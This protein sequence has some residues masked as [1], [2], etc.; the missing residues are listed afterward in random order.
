MG[1]ALRVNHGRRLP[2]LGLQRSRLLDFPSALQYE[3]LVTNGLG[4]YASGT[5][6]GI[7]T[8]RYHGLLMAALRPPVGRTLLFARLHDA[9]EV[10]DDHYPLHAAEYHDGTI[11][12]VGYL[13]LD[14]VF[15]DGRRPVWRY[16]CH[17]VTLEKSLWLEH[18][19][20]TLFVRYRVVAAP[21]RVRLRLEPF[22]THRADHA[23]THGD[24]AWRFLVD[25]QPTHCR[26]EAFPGATPLWLGLAPGHFVETG[27]WYWRFLHRR[28]R[29]RGLDDLEDLYTPGVFVIEMEPGEVAT[30]IA[31]THPEDLAV[32]PERS[33]RRER[34]RTVALLRRA[35]ATADD[36]VR[37]RLVLAADQFLVT[38]GAAGCTILAGYPWFTDWGRDTMI[39]L[40]GLCLATGRSQ[41]AR[42][43][44]AT[45]VTH[46][47]QGLLPNRFPDRGEPPE[48]N[49]VD[50]TLWLFE[51]LARYAQATG[52]RSLVDELLPALQDVVGWH[53]RGTR[54]GIGVDPHDGLL[55]AGAPGVQL[56]WMDAR[57]GDWVVTP[58]HGKPV[59]IQALWYNALRLLTGWLA[60]R[61]Q[62]FSHLDE[63]SERCRVSFDRRFWDPTRNSCFD[64]VDG[65][66]GDDPAL[67]PNQLLAAS[68]SHPVLDP[69]RWEA[70]LGTVERALLTP[71]GLRSLGPT[72]PAYVG[73]YAGD[74]VR[75]DGA[76]HQGTVWAW[77]IGPYVD[78]A[79][80][81]HGDAWDPNSAL[82]GLVRHLGEAG[83]GP[84]SEIFG[85]NPPHRP[86]GCI[87]QAWSVGELLRIWPRSIGGDTAQ[88][89]GAD[90]AT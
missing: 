79:R 14:E 1:A 41:E 38:R 25:S 40:P 20:Q 87:A 47:D 8:R 82:D 72:E 21:G 24:P 5:V 57:V 6:L 3:W 19:R 59:E 2:M 66:T 52:D 27:L 68:L 37:Q 54:H 4:G 33:L 22:V 46:L 42:S 32:D 35:R 86:D 60:E 12:P 48:Y 69:T 55:S 73:T 90:N 56:T 81:V 65:P 7:D 84:V 15:L 80:R 76:Y 31:T 23:H 83:L 17:D 67:R 39:A 53:E 11:H 64:V 75:R 16:R 89:Q 45:F 9:V 50:A 62:D 36:P 88:C 85:G 28:E 77:L 34:A 30:L 70:M 61:G 43:I 78:V 29:E 63:L 44:L 58:R 26:V 74:Q 10:G 18:G 71:V 51:T 13:N 49:T